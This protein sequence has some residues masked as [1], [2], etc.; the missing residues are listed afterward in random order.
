MAVLA[1]GGNRLEANEVQANSGFGIAVD[2]S[3]FN[4]IVGNETFRIEP[5]LPAALRLVH[6]G[7]MTMAPAAGLRPEKKPTA[8]IGG[9]TM[10]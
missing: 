2:R 6:S 10:S 4:E 3:W 7:D 8:G 1:G 9:R 5:L